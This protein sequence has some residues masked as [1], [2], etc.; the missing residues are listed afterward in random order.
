MINYGSDIWAPSVWGVFLSSREKTIVMVDAV[1]G[2]DFAIVS[3]FFMFYLVSTL[4]TKYTGNNDFCSILDVQI[5]KGKE[6][7]YS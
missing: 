4:K 3:A 2:L 7:D 1:W 5:I 6:L